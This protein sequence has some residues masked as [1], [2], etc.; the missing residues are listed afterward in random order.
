MIVARWD[1]NSKSLFFNLIVHKT[2]ILFSVFRFFAFSPIRSVSVHFSLFC[3][4]S[5]TPVLFG[6]SCPFSANFSP[7][8][9]ILSNLVYSVHFDLLWSIQSFFGLIWFIWIILI[10]RLRVPILNS[11]LLK[12]I[13]LKLD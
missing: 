1:E 11:N 8:F 4:F 6:Q 3:P 10:F 12:N 9:S 5:S 2:S 7:L 13:Y